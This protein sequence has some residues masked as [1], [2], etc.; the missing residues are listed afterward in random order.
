MDIN[1]KIK[2]RERRHNR[3]RSKIIG[4]SERPRFSVFRSNRHLYVQ[5]IN[6][7]GNKV[8]CVASDLEIKKAENKKSLIQE[9]GKLISQKAAEKKVKKVVFD[10]GGYKYHG[11]V[12]NLADSA[13]EAGLEF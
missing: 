12:K 7:D 4:T 8:I 3:V 13:R 5:L 10:R 6:D 9:L 11:Q 2:K 1:Q